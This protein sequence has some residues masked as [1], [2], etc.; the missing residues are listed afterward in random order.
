[1]QPLRRRT[2]R[3]ACAIL[4]AS[5]LLSPAAGLAQPREPDTRS[6]ARRVWDG[7]FDVLLLRPLSLP[8]AGVGAA[9][10]VPAVVMT[11]P[12]G[13]RPLSEALEHFVLVPGRYLA[14]RPLGEF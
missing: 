4:T 2:T 12:G 13:K 11:A 5:L 1:M 7:T 10:F 9:L 8:V 3:L 6:T 14:T